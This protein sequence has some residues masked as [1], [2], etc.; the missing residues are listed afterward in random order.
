MD[1]S[2][3]SPHKDIVSWLCVSR[4]GW[5]APDNWTSQSMYIVSSRNQYL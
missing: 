2:H 3:K 5:Q 1:A 4:N